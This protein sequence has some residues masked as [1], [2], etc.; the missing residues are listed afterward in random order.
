MTTGLSGT[1]RAS[2][3][4]AVSRDR[5][6]LTQVL[7]QIVDVSDDLDHGV[8]LPQLVMTSMKAYRE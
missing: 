5:A 2:D 8:L 4:A 7:R 1:R 6:V 3:S